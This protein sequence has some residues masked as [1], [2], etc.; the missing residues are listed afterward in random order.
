VEQA[1]TR[2]LYSITAPGKAHLASNRA[3]ADTILDT[4]SRIGSRMDDVREAFAG[5]GDSDDRRRYRARPF[6]D[7]NDFR[8]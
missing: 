5:L 1:G 8:Q 6:L 2:K 7:S 4:L 3:S